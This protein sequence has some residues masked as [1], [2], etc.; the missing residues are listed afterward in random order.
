MWDC[1]CRWVIFILLLFAFFPNY[2]ALC[3]EQFHQP[4]IKCSMFREKI[5][6]CRGALQ[7]KT[8]TLQ[9][10]PLNCEAYTVQ[11]TLGSLHKTDVDSALWEF[12]YEF[13]YPYPTGTDREKDHWVYICRLLILTQRITMHCYI[14]DPVTLSSLH[15]SLH[16]SQASL[17]IIY[18]SSPGRLARGVVVCCWTLHTHTPTHIHGHQISSP[19]LWLSEHRHLLFTWE[20]M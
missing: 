12:T 1:S 20:A 16:Q 10:K 2:F 17:W 5:T 18:F 3:T 13:F 8:S 19:C 4:S 11:K 9:L 14:H 15:S 6:S 7:T